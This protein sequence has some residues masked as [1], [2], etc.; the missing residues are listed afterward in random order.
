M[1][2]LIPFPFPFLHPYDML[3]SVWCKLLPADTPLH[4]GGLLLGLAHQVKV[5]QPVKK[6]ESEL[7]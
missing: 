5:M 6:V 7:R 3:L 2:R 4:M 1:K